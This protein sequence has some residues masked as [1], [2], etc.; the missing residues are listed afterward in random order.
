MRS[1]V[2]CLLLSLAI[3]VNFGYA[4][5]RMISLDLSGQYPLTIYQG[6]EIN[7][8]NTFDTNLYDLTIT[9][10]PLS[11]EILSVSEFFI[12]QSFTLA[13]SKTGTYEVCFSK[14]KNAAQTCLNLD[15]LKRIAT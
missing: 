5:P 6:S 13:F 2:F 9:K 10:P 7:V 11:K 12:G 1:F 15:V 14:E 4:K 3:L 8:S